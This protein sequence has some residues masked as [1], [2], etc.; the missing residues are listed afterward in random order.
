MLVIGGL[1]AAVLGYWYWKKHMRHSGMGM[2]RSMVTA[3][4][5]PP[6]AKKRGWRSRMGKVAGGAIRGAAA[7]SGIPGAGAALYVAGA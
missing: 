1:I 7:A 5:P 3:A 2:R 6:K 4:A